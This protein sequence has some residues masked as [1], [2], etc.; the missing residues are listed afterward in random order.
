MQQLVASLPADRCGHLS[1]LISTTEFYCLPQAINKFDTRRAS[2]EMRLNA[3]TIGWWKIEIQ[4][5]RQE[6]ENLFASLVR[7]IGRHINLSS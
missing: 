6:S 5:I 3:C 4:V 7:N 2:S 1:R